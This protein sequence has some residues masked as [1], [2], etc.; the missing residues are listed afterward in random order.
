[1]GGAPDNAILLKEQTQT[2]NHGTDGISGRGITMVFPAAPAF[3]PLLSTLTGKT[4][5]TNIISSTNHA[6]VHT[7]YLQDGHSTKAES[8]LAALVEAF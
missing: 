3:L 2:V 1:V 8:A 4:A 7:L 5:G 6:R